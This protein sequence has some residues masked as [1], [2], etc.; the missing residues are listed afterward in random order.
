MRRLNILVTWCNTQKKNYDSDIQK[1][2]DIMKNPEIKKKWEEFMEEFPI[3][4]KN[5][6][7]VKKRKKI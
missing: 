1:C 7:W 5:Q 3:C 4:L 6:K 2:K